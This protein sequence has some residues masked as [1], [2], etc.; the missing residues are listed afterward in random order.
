MARK[1]RIHYHGALYHVIARGNNGEYILDSD[2]DKKN[3]IEILK[4]YKERYQFELYAYCIMDNHVHLLMEVG[5]TPLNKIMQG[6][7]QVYTQRYNKKNKRTGHVFQQRYKAEVCKKDG[8]L[9]HLVKYI[10]F[11]PVKAGMTKTVEYKW[12]SHNNYVKCINE[13]VNTE[14]VLKVISSNKAVA[15][16]GYKEYM[17]EK[18][19]E[20]EPCEY[21]VTEAQ[22][23]TPNKKETGKILEDIINKILEKEKITMKELMSGSKLQKISDI[24]K[25]VVILADAD[26]SNKEISDK[27]NISASV[28]SRVKAKEFKKTDYLERIISEYCKA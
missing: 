12:N 26:I 9:L 21:E 14:Y 22:R 24:R 23:N 25:A 19:E 8:Y 17:K 2:E 28:I 20:I 4:R 27:L 13:I 18:I 10:H 11:N 3:Y 5:E 1:Q 16:K 6:I 15:L 7:Q